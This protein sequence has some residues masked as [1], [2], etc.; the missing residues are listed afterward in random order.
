MAV[1][2]RVRAFVLIGGVARMTRHVGET[3]IE[4]WIGWRKGMTAEQLAAALGKFRAIDPDNYVGAAKHGPV[5][6]QCGNF[7]FINVE[8]CVDLERAA[9]APKEVRWYD[10][11][12]PFADVEATFD[13]MRW[14]EAQLKLKPVKPLLDRLWT[15]PRK[16]GEPVRVK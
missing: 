9:S 11:D 14:L 3:E 6:L 5:L 1:E 8:P 15:D 12:H 16:Q 2:P 7:D 10:T 4:P 13:R